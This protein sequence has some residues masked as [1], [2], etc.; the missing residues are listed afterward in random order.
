MDY[1]ALTLGLALPWLLGIALLLAL[2]WPQSPAHDGDDSA[3]TAALRL[4]YGYF[5]GAIPK[6]QG[7]AK[8][9]VSA[10]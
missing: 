1:L 2:D 3:G 10:R 4:G 6:S 5:I 7:N 8:P 9:S